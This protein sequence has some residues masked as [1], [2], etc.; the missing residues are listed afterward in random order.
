[1]SRTAST[2]DVML[3]RVWKIAHRPRRLLFSVSSPREACTVIQRLQAREREDPT[4]R[5][6]NY[7][8]EVLAAAGWTEWHDSH[9]HDVTAC[10]RAHNARG[11]TVD[12][13]VDGVDPP[14]AA[15]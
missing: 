10:L 2:E 8:L 14:P 7:G 3:Y 4:A 6:A 15:G 13:P 9:G 12:G 1:M 5:T 11:D